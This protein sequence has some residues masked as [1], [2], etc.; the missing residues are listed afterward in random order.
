MASWI[1]VWRCLVLKIQ[2]NQDFRERL[3][4]GSFALSGLRDVGLM[5]SQGVALG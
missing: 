2:M 3:W 5:S 1:R 4:H